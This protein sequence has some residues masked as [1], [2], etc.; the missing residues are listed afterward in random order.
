MTQ[1]SYTLL[2]NGSS[3]RVNHNANGRS[4]VVIGGGI[5]G[6]AAARRL[7]TLTSGTDTEIVL[8][9]A[10]NAWWKIRTSRLAHHIDESADAFLLRTPHAVQLASSVGLGEQLV[11]PTSASAESGRE[12]GAIPSDLALGVPTSLTAVARSGLLPTALLERPISFG[13]GAH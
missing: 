5:T 8:L 4:I 12:A 1:R 9:G 6:I 11:S 10:E 7:V 3:A 2:L 13:L